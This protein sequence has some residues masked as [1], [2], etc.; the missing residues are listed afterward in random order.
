MW[1]QNQGWKNYTLRHDSIFW[2]PPQLGK[3]LPGLPVRQLLQI[4]ALE[5]LSG[6]QRPQRKG[7]A[8]QKPPV[9]SV[10]ME[11]LK[12]GVCFRFEQ[13]AVYIP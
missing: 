12:I 9:D 5:A 11:G 6:H 8:P 3:V 13:F 4:G 10:T 2:G 1:P 7:S